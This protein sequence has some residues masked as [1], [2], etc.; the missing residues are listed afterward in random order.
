LGQ[1]VELTGV[2]VKEPDERAAITNLE[3]RLEN[4]EKI[5]VSVDKHERVSYGDKLVVKGKLEQPKNFVTDFGREFDYQGYLKARGILYRISFAEVEVVEERVGNWFIYSLLQFKQSFMSNLERLIPEPAVGLGE[6]LLLGVK[7]A[8]GEDL[9]SAFRK[10]GLIHIVV[11]S[12]F[13]VMLVVMFIMFIL[14][15]VFRPWWRFVFGVVAIFCFALLVGLSATVV[16]ASIM[17][18][19]LLWAQVTGRI[20]FVLRGLLVAGSNNAFYQSLLTFLRRWFSAF[21]FGYTW[22][23][24]YFTLW[25]TLAR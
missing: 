24:F 5:L 22:S 6:G 25:G 11:L 12:G 8:L 4:E 13:N 20:Y 17:A 3:V 21:V 15:S 10:T 1:E 14:K 23:D 19:I 2:V 18:V 9:E 16:R 7:S